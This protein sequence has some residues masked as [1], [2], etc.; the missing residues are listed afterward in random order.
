MNDDLK[1][2]PGTEPRS[3]LHVTASQNSE[4]FPLL[5]DSSQ[6][7][8]LSPVMKR[9]LAIEHLRAAFRKGDLATATDLMLRNRISFKVYQETRREVAAQANTNVQPRAQ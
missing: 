1:Q 9:S 8:R 6:S 4:G 3:A 5:P 7:A 2:W